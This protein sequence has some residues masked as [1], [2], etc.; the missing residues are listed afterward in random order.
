MRYARQINCGTSIDGLSD[1]AGNVS[2]RLR[3]HAL[4]GVQD[5][6]TL[7]KNRILGTLSNL[8]AESTAGIL[9]S[10]KMR[11]GSRCSMPANLDWIKLYRAVLKEPIFRSVLL[12]RFSS[13]ATH[14]TRCLTTRLSGKPRRQPGF[15]FLR[16]QSGELR[17]AED[18]LCAMWTK[19]CSLISTAKLGLVA[20]ISWS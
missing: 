2:G 18:R 9:L 6:L 1:P 13:S 11:V 16:G 5:G 8:S 15:R 20:N 12:G 3:V 7:T 14:S 10:S 19:S 17:S 4:A